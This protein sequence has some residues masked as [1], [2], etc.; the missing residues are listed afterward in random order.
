MESMESTITTDAD[1]LL[2]DN[3]HLQPYLHPEAW[4][5][6]PSLACRGVAVC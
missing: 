5:R 2:H 6:R 3:V 1:F 4:R